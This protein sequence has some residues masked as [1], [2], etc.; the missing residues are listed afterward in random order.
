MRINQKSDLKIPSFPLPIYHTRNIAEAISKEGD[1]FSI[2]VGLDKEKVS[3]LEKLSLDENDMEVQKNTSDKKRF[4]NKSY[5]NWYKKNRIP[6]ALIHSAT[7]SLAALIW[8][9]P[10]SLNRK[11]ENWHTV[12]WRSYPS[13][14]G[15]GLMKEFA[16]FAMDIYSKKISNAKFWITVKKE[17]IGS[18]KLAKFLGFHE[19]ENTPASNVYFIMIK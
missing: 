13:F 2:F 6:F 10:E 5:E 12:A 4:G 19:L 16:K 11:S 3:Q 1:F 15:K 9:G 7:N 14:R 8:F 17:N 18:I